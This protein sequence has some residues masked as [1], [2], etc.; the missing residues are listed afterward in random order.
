MHAESMGSRGSS[1]SSNWSFLQIGVPYLGGPR[2]PLR[3]PLRVLPGIYKDLGFRGALL[4]AV[5]VIRIPLFWVLYY[6]GDQNS[7]KALYRMVFGP[8]SLNI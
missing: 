1:A 4:W 6:L 8:K 2:V 3:V 5:L 7:P